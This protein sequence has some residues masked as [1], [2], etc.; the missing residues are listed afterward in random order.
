MKPRL[1]LDV[2]NPEH[3]AAEAQLTQPLPELQAQPVLADGPWAPKRE[4]AAWAGPLFFVDGRF[5]TDALLYL[6]EAPALLVSVAVGAVGLEPGRAFFDEAS[7]AVRR[8]LVAPPGAWP[9]PRF[10][11]APGLDYELVEAAAEPE[12][13]R[14]AAME[15]RGEL[16]MGLGE[17]LRARHPGALVLHDGPLHRLPAAASAGRLGFAKTHHRGYLSAAHAALLTELAAGQRTPVFAFERGE[18]RFYSWYLRLP[19][20]PDRPYAAAATLLRVET[21]APEAEALELARVSLGIFPRL[22]SRPFRDPRA[23][24]NLVPVGALERELGRRLGSAALIRRRLLEHIKR[25]AV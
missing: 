19:L 14:A 3:A 1:R 5:R 21:A 25:E 12:A 2:W 8:Y 9:E 18:R 7:F 11:P 24:Q 4:A 23:P 17:G 15:R 13:L 16:E 20:E 10:S 6:D 22:A